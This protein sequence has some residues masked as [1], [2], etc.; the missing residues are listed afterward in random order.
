M[1]FFLF[2]CVIHMYG[3]EDCVLTRNVGLFD[4]V[5]KLSGLICQDV[6]YA[7]MMFSSLKDKYGRW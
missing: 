2:T 4:P 1:T 7:F 3:P 5:T 6:T